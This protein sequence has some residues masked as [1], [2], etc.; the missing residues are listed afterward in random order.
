[1]IPIVFGTLEFIFKSGTVTNLALMA[2]TIYRH[3][4]GKTHN[5]IRIYMINKKS[6]HQKFV[7]PE[8]LF[9]DSQK[10][11]TYNVGRN[12]AKRAKKLANKNKLQGSN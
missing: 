1:M 10:N 4:G 6:N 11:G 2:W 7:W 8:R 9:W 5:S 12:K 3:V